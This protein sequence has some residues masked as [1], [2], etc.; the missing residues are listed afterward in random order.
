[1][2][3]G[4]KIRVPGYSQRVFYNNNIE[5]RNFSDDLVG[6]QQTV[7]D[8]E[9]ASLFTMG[10]FVVSV[11]L[12]D[13]S[14]SLFTTKQYSKF[15]DLT[16]L[17][18]NESYQKLIDSNVK[19]N[20]NLDNSEITN[21]A[22][23]GSAT[24]F[25]RVSLEN[26]ITNWPASLYLTYIKDYGVNTISGYTFQDYYYDAYNNKATFKVDNNFITNNF[27]IVYE[28]NGSLLNTFN[29]TNSLRNL[30]INYSSYVI[31]YNNEEYRLLNFT[32]S[33][34][35]T[36]GYIYLEVEGNP[37]ST[38]ANT[39]NGIFT[40]HIR[41][42]KLKGDEF[43]NTL[44]TFENNLL[45]RL[46]IPKYTSK[47][48][49]TIV[50][51]NGSIYE[52]SKTL[53]WPVSDGYNIDF[54]TSEYSIYVN[55]LIEITTGIDEISSNLVNRFFVSQSISNFDT[56]PRLDGNYEET[57]GQ[58]M[59][60]TLK[61]Y[62]REFD[63]IKKWIDGIKYA[64]NVTYDKNNN[65][66]DQL[67]KYLAKTLGWQLTSS[68]AE[69]DLLKAYV[70]TNASTYSGQSRGLTTQ[71][72]EV[73]MWRRLILNSAWLWKSKGTRK[74]IE[75]FFKFIGAPKGLIDLN[76]YIYKAKDKIDMDLFYT[77][78]NRFNLSTDLT[79]YHVDEDGYP[80]FFDNN[81]SMYYQKGGLW[82]RETGGSAAT[83]TVLFGNN[84]HVG[85]YDSGREYIAQLQNL[86]PN[87][88]PFTIT[89]TS[90]IT[91]N[92]NLFSN[93]NSGKINGYTGNL[94]VDVV[95]ENNGSVSSCIDLSKSVI[96]DPYPVYDKDICGCDCDDI[97][98]IIKVSLTKKTPKGPCEDVV[99][100]SLANSDSVYY[101]FVV[102]QKALDGSQKLDENNNSVKINT[103]FV[104]KEC[105]SSYGGKSILFVKRTVSSYNKGYAC[106]TA[107]S[108]SKNLCGCSVGCKWQPMAES[109]NILTNGVNTQYMIFRDNNDAFTPEGYGRRVVTPDG[110]HCYY[111]I[112]EKVANITD[113]YTGEVGFGCKLTKLGI[114]DLQRYKTYNTWAADTTGTLSQPIVPFMVELYKVKAAT[115]TN[116]GC[117]AAKVDI[118]T[119]S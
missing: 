2:A 104:N 100:K 18:I 105:C 106:C 70:E 77:I 95:N 10:N 102:Y 80:K 41:P 64:N 16:N 27:D 49:Y 88:T 35:K 26:I 47:Y 40:Y 14:T 55:N 74:A 38:T 23:F 6:N 89:N 78:L 31:D 119:R 117:C 52:T 66:P 7:G 54:N 8:D 82:Y 1:M 32:G 101:D 118:Y 103:N 83:E 44:P 90:T 42:N 72:A 25:I 48:N 43:F 86:I 33:T 93:Y 85:P 73:E 17:N 97:D 24:E 58:K 84:P 28:L 62:G 87:F 45:N 51:S 9:N 19:I 57:A 34:S 69:N 3:K 56:I 60:K 63:E 59:N 113:P 21:Y 111:D 30:T 37:F 94:Y 76:E 50:T 91:N 81:S 22:Y 112:S 116:V 71:E 12:S 65:I 46:V 53:T 29:E 11:N 110:S 96:S 99:S 36:N 20:L 61:I 98:D 4:D 107:S 67:I 114:I 68:I 39:Q 5:Y 79:G 15:F 75:F 92:T 108:I 109:V 115:T 13:R